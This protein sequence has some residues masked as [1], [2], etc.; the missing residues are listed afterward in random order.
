M[1]S[2]VRPGATRLQGFL[3]ASNVVDLMEKFF[4]LQ[5]HAVQAVNDGE[6]GSVTRFLQRWLSEPILVP[7]VDKT[8]YNI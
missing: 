3:K 1:L 2:S 4:Q 8:V 6:C 5:R 7:N